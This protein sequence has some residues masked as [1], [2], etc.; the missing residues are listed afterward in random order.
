MVAPKEWYGTVDPN[1]F[2]E[3]EKNI[4]PPDSRKVGAQLEG[5]T[6]DGQ[7]VFSL[8]PKVGAGTA[9]LDFNHPLASDIHHFNVKVMDVAQAIAPKYGL[10]SEAAREAVPPREYQFSILV[11]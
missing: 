3:V 6:A 7:A 8:V 5:K 4:T 1:A 2:Q 11:D 9:L 10:Y